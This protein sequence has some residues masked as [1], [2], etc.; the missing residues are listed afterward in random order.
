MNSSGGVVIA[1]LIRKYPEDIDNVEQGRMVEN[2][3]TPQSGRGRYRTP[4]TSMLDHQYAVQV[5][6]NTANTGLPYSAEV[7]SGGRKEMPRDVTARGF[8]KEV[9]VESLEERSDKRWLILY[10]LRQRS[11]RCQSTL[12]EEDP[13]GSR[14][15]KMRL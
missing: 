8:I 10:Q 11:S 14:S 7:R 1:D 12:I 4:R 6:F 5:M 9:R 2:L 15:G 3:D 13:Y